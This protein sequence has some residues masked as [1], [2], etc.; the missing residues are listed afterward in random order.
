MIPQGRASQKGAVNRAKMLEV[1]LAV[2]PI[3]TSELYDLF[4][5]WS[6]STV[7]N[8]INALHKAGEIHI[9]EW[10]RQLDGHPGPFGRVWAA[11]PG[12]DAPK[13]RP[14]THNQTCREYY[15]RNAARIS[16]TRSGTR[17][18]LN[19]SENPFAALI[20]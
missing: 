14:K 1:I 12:K 9:H 20:R 5:A 4:S 13:P 17:S 15:Q 6:L 16:V 19:A 10:T 3:G 18:R 8:N 7:T 2:G 11:G